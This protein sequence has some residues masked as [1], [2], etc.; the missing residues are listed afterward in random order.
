MVSPWIFVILGFFSAIGGCGVVDEPPSV[1]ARTAVQVAKI[2]REIRN[3]SGVANLEFGILLDLF[4][5]RVSL[6]VAENEAIRSTKAHKKSAKE[7]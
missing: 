5:E 4:A 3:R 6:Q 1:W 7:R 2:I